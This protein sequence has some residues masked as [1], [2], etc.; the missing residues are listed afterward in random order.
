MKDKIYSICYF[1]SLI[2]FA[3]FMIM[4]G[5]ELPSLPPLTACHW[6]FIIQIFEQLSGPEKQSRPE[7]FHC[8][9]IF[10]IFEDFWATC[11]CPEKQNVPWIHCIEYIYIWPFRILNNMRFLWKT[12]FA[13]KF[14]TALK[15]F[16][17]FRIF[18]KLCACPE[19]SLS[20]NFWLYLKY[21]LHSGCMSNLCLSWKTVCPEFTVLNIFF[22]I[23]NFEQPALALKQF[24]MKFFTVLKYFLSFRIWATWVALKRPTPV[25]YATGLTLWTIESW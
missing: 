12:Y 17:Y 9:E 4:V 21:L 11:A 13:L 8:V 10:F 16:L 18:E 1:W 15:Y 24:S 22:I 20:W 5:E 7:T 14:F 23:Q 25:S 19:K 6:F 3:H 2:R